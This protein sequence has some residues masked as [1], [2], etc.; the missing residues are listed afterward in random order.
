MYTL[1]RMSVRAGL[2]DDSDAPDFS[3]TFIGFIEK[4]GR[5]FELGLA[6]RYHLT[7]KPLRKV[8]VG[9]MAV[10]LLARDRL[11]LRPKPIKGVKQL[12]AILKRAKELGGV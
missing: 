3:K 6:T 12:Q 1:K 7:H 10:G 4:Y 8:G 5:S 11:P 2:Y 9:P